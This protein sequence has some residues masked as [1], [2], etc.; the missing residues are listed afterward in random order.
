MK[1]MKL[2]SQSKRTK[3]KNFPLS[4]PFITSLSITF[5]LAFSYTF[6]QSNHRLIEKTAI[7]TINR[8]GNRWR[9]RKRKESRE[10]EQSDYIRELEKA[11]NFPLFGVQ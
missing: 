2:I 3:K 10:K 6:T 4:L 7:R 8:D 11:I 1:K 9:K 5:F